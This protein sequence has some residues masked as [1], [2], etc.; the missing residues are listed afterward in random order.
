M[1]LIQKILEAD[2]ELFLLLNSFYS[3]YRDVIMLIITR[4]EIWI[5][6]YLIIL[7][8]FIKNYRSKSLLI[9]IF[10]AL[11]IFL[12]D[13]LSVFVKEAVQR[14]RPSH[15]PEIQH[16]VHNVFRKGSLYGF[17]SSHAANTF[18]VWI[19]TS[20]I[21]RSRGYSLLMFFWALVISLSRIYL[22]VHYPLDIVGGAVLGIFIAYIC[23]KMLIFTDIHFFITLDSRIEKTNLKAR[24]AGMITFVFLLLIVTVFLLI[25]ILQ[26]YQYL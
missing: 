25:E 2:T 18:G 4:K 12:S 10:L 9:F 7:Y 16:L 19:F 8:F 24:Q 15:N 13:Q 22:G 21:F 17:V 6:V 3:D 20:R 26:Y 23:Y 14:L 1:N 11:T 5:P